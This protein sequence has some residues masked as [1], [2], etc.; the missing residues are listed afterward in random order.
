[1]GFKSK[2]WYWLALL[3]MLMPLILV[4]CTRP[5]TKSEPTAES[6][7]T[8][9]ATATP[10]QQMPTEPTATEPPAP[11]VEATNEAIMATEQAQ[12]PAEPTE[13]APDEATPVPT[14]PVA[15]PTTPAPTQEQSYTIVANDTLFSIAQR[16]G[17]SVEELA[18]RNGIVSVD[19][20]EVGQVL[21]IPVPGAT[22][23]EPEPPS[24]VERVHVVQ[25]GE[26]LFR[27]ALKYN[28]SFES[29]AAYNNI[30]WPY[31]IYPGQDIKIPPSE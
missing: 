4:G 12:Q 8:E 16:Y 27:V 25:A 28:M 26:N 3:V 30:P 6:G 1:M 18:A 20:I 23:P 13:P 19:R 7:E 2:H 21:V 9:T 17:V 5:A 24:A 15:E 10:A 29:V 31:H 14:E 22:E 11:D